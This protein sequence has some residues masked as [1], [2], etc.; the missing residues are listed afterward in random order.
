[1]KANAEIAPQLE[2]TPENWVAEFGAEG[3]VQTPIGEVK[4]GANQ[5]Q[6][7]TQSSRRTK[8]G[9]VKPTLL[10]AAQMY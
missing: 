9:M 1:M 3:V 5:Y 4:M 2:L 6:K 8:L 10:R 7:M